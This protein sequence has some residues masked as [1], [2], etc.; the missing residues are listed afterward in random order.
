MFTGI[1]KQTGRISKTSK[2]AEGLG[3]TVECPALIKEVS[4]GDSVAVDGC[5]LTVDS[6]QDSS[7][8]AFISYQT[9][10]NTTLKHVEP[11]A[12]VNLEPALSVGSRMGGHMVTGH[13]DFVAAI[14]E[15][16]NKGD[17]FRMVL[18][19]EGEYSPFIA[20]R[21]SVAI[22]GISLTVSEKDGGW[23]GVAVIPHTYRS[24]TLHSK[25]AGSRVNIEVDIIARYVA[26]Y[27]GY[28]NKDKILE[29][30]LKKYGFI[31]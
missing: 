12:A 18:T 30:K 28:K 23:F 11:G 29:E 10:Q 6:M 13:V 16:E 14:K 21:G 31:K 15:I 27:I 5:C 19:L 7:F 24:T 20:R 2:Q 22:D 9:L 1:I 17:A 26:N 4:V 8:S 3:L 25:K